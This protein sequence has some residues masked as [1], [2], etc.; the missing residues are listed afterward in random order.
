VRDLDGLMGAK[1]RGP[2]GILGCNAD[3]PRKKHTYKEFFEP[4]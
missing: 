2:V 4:R 1:G 3:G